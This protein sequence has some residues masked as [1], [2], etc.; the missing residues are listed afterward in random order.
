MYVGL[1]GERL[2]TID[3]IT[4]SYSISRAHLMK[5]VHRLGMEGYIETIRG[6]N[7]GIRLA[8]TPA[9]INI[10]DVMARMEDDFHLVECFNQSKNQC[11]LYGP[12]KLG[13]ILGEALEAYLQVLRKY[14]LADLLGDQD[15]FKKLFAMTG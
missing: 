6:R 8:R 13:P 12:C 4:E 3:E 2:S 10:G 9:E 7:G 11:V 15:A 1:K 5:V 14:T